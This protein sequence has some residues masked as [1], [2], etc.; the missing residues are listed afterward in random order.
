MKTPLLRQLFACAGLAAFVTP[1]LDA[2]VLVNYSFTAG[3]AA[4][5][6]QDANVTATNATWTGLSGA[7]FSPGTGGAYAPANAVPTSFSTGAYLS[8]T[9]TADPGFTLNLDNLVFDLGAGMNTSG[10]YT[11]NTNVRSNAEASDFTTDLTMTPGPVTTASVSNTTGSGTTWL[12][13]T[14]DLSGTDFENLTSITFRFYP[15]DN[16]SGSNQWARYNNITL[17]GSVVPEPASALL[18]TLSLVGLLVFRR[19]PF[20]TRFANDPLR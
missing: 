4:P 12:T 19:L 15:T 8:F 11:V 16:Q 14:V 10:T 17:N 18:L 20:Q 6:T 1:S 5:T 2:A 9:I 7:T 13:Y 3:S